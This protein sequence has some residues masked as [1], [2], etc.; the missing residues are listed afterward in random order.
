MQN[1]DSG[2]YARKTLDKQF[3]I[4]GD[5]LQGKTNYPIRISQYMQIKTSLKQTNTTIIGNKPAYSNI[6]STTSQCLRATSTQRGIR[7][8]H[9]HR[10]LQAS[11]TEEN[12]RI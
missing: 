4:H 9:V 2:W 3:Q 6:A 10:D 8:T 1:R 7:A 12:T 5:R 11:E